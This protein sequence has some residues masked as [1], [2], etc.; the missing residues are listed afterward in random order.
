MG[1]DDYSANK[2]SN[3]KEALDSIEIF[4][5]AVSADLTRQSMMSSSNDASKDTSK[6]EDDTKKDDTKKDEKKDDVGPHGEIRQCEK[7]N[8]WV[9]DRPHKCEPEEKH[10]Y[11]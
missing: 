1:T 11:A 2:K 10:K 4:L 7:C 5:Q 3:Q 9:D 8:C 6:K